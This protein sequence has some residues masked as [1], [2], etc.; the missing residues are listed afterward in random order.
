LGTLGQGLPK[1]QCCRGM[2]QVARQQD[3]LAFNQ[4]TLPFE[5]VV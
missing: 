1:S 2:A 3:L 4:Q 5:K